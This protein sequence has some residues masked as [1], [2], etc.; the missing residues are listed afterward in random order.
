MK[1]QQTRP[2]GVFGYTLASDKAPTYIQRE[3]IPVQVETG[4]G[5]LLVFRDETERHKL[6]RAR[7]E[8]SQL[9]IHDLRS[10]LTAVTS[11]VAMS[12]P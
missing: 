8:F 9:I 5:T 1:A 2:T 3:V 4:A 7:E 6:D 10:P 12:M 11:S